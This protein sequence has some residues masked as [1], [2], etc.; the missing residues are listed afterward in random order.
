MSMPAEQEP[1][2]L[3]LRRSLSEA[4]RRIEEIV[5]TAERVAAEI[6]ADAEAEADRYLDERRR[7][8]ERLA[9][10]RERTLSDLTA[11]LERRASRLR[12]EIDGMVGEL[13]TAI[14]RLRG[15]AAPAPASGPLAASRGMGAA[16]RP[17]AYS[18]QSTADTATKSREPEIVAEARGP[19]EPLLRA[20]QM[21]VAGS[22]RDEIERT[23]IDEFG[24]SDPGSI[25]DAVLGADAD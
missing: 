2:G 1:G 12:G 19:E 10:E 16:S 13:E 22:S 18:G 24:V 21:A 25:V 7:E 3:G 6:L 20:T 17:T 11:S 9:D 8:A 23:L 4:T 15:L 5:D 14:A